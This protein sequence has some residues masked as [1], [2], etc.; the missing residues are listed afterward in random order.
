MKEPIQPHEKFNVIKQIMDALF[1]SGGYVDKNLVLELLEYNETDLRK[2][3]REIKING[4]LDE[5]TKRD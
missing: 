4:F 2:L 1:D 5:D 3:L